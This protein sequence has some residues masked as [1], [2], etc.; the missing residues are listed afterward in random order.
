MKTIGGGSEGRLGL[1]ILLFHEFTFLKY[2]F[3][4][5]RYTDTFKSTL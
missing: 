4:G 3:Q 2:F 5:W 1:N